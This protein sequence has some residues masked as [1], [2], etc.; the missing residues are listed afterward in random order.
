MNYNETLFF[1]G[2]CLTINHDQHNRIIVEKELKSKKTDWESVVK[3]STSHYVFPALYCNLKKARFLH[4]LPEDLVEYMKHITDLNRERNKQII[5]QAKEINQLLISNNITPI[6][7]K[8]TGNLLEG[9]Y[10]D[11]AERMVGD[12]DFLV[13]NQEYLTAIELLK[14]DG[15]TYV[16]N[17]K[18]HFPHQRHYYRIKKNNRISAVEIHDEVIKKKYI[19]IFN[20]TF[21]IKDILKKDN[22]HF[23]SDSNKLNLSIIS[24]HINDNGRFFKDISL[25]NAYDVFLLSKKTNALQAISHLN[26]LSHHLNC[27]LASCFYTLG[28]INSLKYFKNKKTSKYIKAF[29]NSISKKRKTINKTITIYLYLKLRLSL[30]FKAFYSKKARIWLYGLLNDSEWQNKT[31]SNLKLKKTK[32]NS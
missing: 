19:N 8:G 13:S 7:L 22:E 25:R 18:Y 10:D 15:Y 6:F 24:K 11:I 14:I 9:L 21:L 20:Y 16:S 31:L 5:E 3:V 27:F 2:K 12:I 32:P 4:Y 30:F 29:F 26:S 23:L 17:K 1:I 28:S